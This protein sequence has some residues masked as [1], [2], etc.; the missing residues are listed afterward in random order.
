MEEAKKQGRFKGPVVG[1]IGHFIQ[2]I[3]GKEEFAAIAELA[4]GSN[5]LN[6]FIVTN[7]EDRKTL[8]QIR[9]SVGCT[10]ECG[11]IQT[12]NAKRF[13]VPAT[14]IPGVETVM[15]V[16][17]IE[18]DLVFNVL[19]DNSKIDKAALCRDKLSSEKLLLTRDSHG[20]D[21]IKDGIANVYFLPKGDYWTV[22]KGS[23]AIFS[24]YKP[25]K[26]TIGVDQ[27]QALRQAQAEADQLE[28]DL[29]AASTEEKR[30][31]IEH[32]KT[33]KDWNRA[34]QA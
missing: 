19:V 34:K 5:T 33:Q 21:A 18:N 31:E 2:M 10:G 16:L 20:Q 28:K 30:L 7:N 22:K 8:D 25:L 15:S 24:N 1:P 23:R 11:I 32:T 26:R 3:G 13:N 4:M 9:K 6:R 29:Q 14:S 27:T 12:K 17:K